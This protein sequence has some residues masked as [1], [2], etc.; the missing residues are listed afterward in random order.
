MRA[1]EFWQRRGPAATLLAP[2][3]M[4]YGASVAWKARH[5]QPYRAAARVI[6]IGNLTAGGSGK[7]P[8]ALAV[9]ARLQ[10]RGKHVF[11][12]TRGYGGSARGP[13]QVEADSDAARMGDEALLLARRAPTIVSRDRAQGAAVAA[14]HGAQS[15]V[16]DDG[17][18]NFG[19]AK[20]LS[21]VVVDGQSGFGNGL[22]IPAG[23]LRE[24]VAR[25]LARADAVV[26]MN[27]GEPDLHGYKGPVLRARLTAESDI[28]RDQQVFAFAGI[29]RPEK[30]LV[31]L[32]EAGAIVTGTHFFADHHPFRS[33]EIAALKVQA[34]QARL[35]T[36]EKDYVRLDPQDRAGITVLP[37]RATFE[38]QAA[39]D[40][41][42]DRIA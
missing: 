42:L 4:L 33:G 37:V 18:Q 14:A 30:F 36:T 10:A 35:V 15:I 20:D 7:T 9:A 16:M 8:V 32:K 11:F 23:P 13:L 12:L 17:H 22:M 29:G 34:G 19:L 27:K 26:V 40:L 1:P 5:A 6:C 41:L 25:G 3:G 31:S 21:I 28:L 24:P 2:L 39:L 38:D